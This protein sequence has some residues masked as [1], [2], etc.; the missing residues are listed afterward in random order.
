MK[1]KGVEGR[2]VIFL[3]GVC[4]SALHIC[5]IDSYVTDTYI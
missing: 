1:G 3:V 2:G 4:G 5:A